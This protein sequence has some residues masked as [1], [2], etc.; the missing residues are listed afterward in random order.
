MMKSLA[1]AG[2]VLICAA[3]TSAAGDLPVRVQT[4]GKSLVFSS[5]S[6]AVLS[7]CNVYL[8]DGYKA[9]LDAVPASGSTSLNL[10]EFV[11][12]GILRFEPRVEPV[13]RVH[14]I[15]QSP[16]GDALFKLQ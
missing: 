1:A 10:G 7:D 13:R 16:R 3:S 2:L 4:D 14:V 6:G 9:H 8:N 5:P 12:K 11:S 15:C